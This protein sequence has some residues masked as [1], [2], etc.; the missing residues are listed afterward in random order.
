MNEG[1]NAAAAEESDEDAG[2]PA[3]LVRSAARFTGGG[4]GTPEGERELGA[5]QLTGDAAHSVGAE[6]AAGH[7]MT[8]RRIG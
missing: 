8:L 2:H 7:E 1:K 5:Q 4:R 6:Q 3:T